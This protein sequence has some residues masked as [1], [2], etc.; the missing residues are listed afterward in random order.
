MIFV[1]LLAIGMGLFVAPAHRQRRAVAAIEKAHGKV[2]YA[3]ESADH[4]FFQAPQWLRDFLGDDYFKSVEEV[5]L[6]MS[7]IDD[8]GLEIL[9]DLPS[10]KYLDLHE[11]PITDAGLEHLKDM[12][13]LQELHLGGTKIGDAGL[14]HLKRLT[15]LVRLDLTGTKISSAGLKNITGLTA[16][17]SIWLTNTQIDDAAVEH[18]KGLSTLQSLWIDETNVTAAGVTKL[19]TALPHC[20]INHPSYFEWLEK[21]NPREPGGELH[22][23]PF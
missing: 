16:P 13:T 10:L 1:T 11:A 9:K 6:R 20:F 12:T 17:H 18:L 19:R 14:A 22:L 15:G 5:E 8:A 7:K 4:G 23:A 21:T 3:V 2:V